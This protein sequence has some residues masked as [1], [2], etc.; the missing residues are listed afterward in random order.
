MLEN[1]DRIYAYGLKTNE[2]G[3]NNHL[4]LMG[5]TFPGGQGSALADLYNIKSL[6]SVGEGHS[7]KQLGKWLETQ[8]NKNVIAS[9]HSKGAT[10]SMIVGAKWPDKIK[11]ANCLNPTGLSGSTLRRYHDTWVN[12]S[13]KPAINVLINEGDIVPYLDMGYLPGTTIRRIKRDTPK[14]SINFN[15]PSFLSFL[16][17]GYEDHIHHKA[18][19]ENATVE[20][21]SVE[22]MNKASVRPVFNNMRA[23]VSWL[24]FPVAYLAVFTNIVGRKFSRFYQQHKHFILGLLLLAGIALLLAISFTPAAPAL[25]SAVSVYLMLMN[26]P[27]SALTIGTISVVLVST[28]AAFAPLITALAGSHLVSVANK[29]VL[30]VFKAFALVTGLTLGALAGF[31]E[32]GVRA[33]FKTSLKEGE[34]S[35]IDNNENT[36]SWLPGSLGSNSTGG[37]NNKSPRQE[38]NASKQSNPTLNTTE[39]TTEDKDKDVVHAL[40]SEFTI[41]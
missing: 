9:G 26:L 38:V 13:N 5:T 29:V 21:V 7:F 35:K 16:A 37:D 28:A 40:E 15:F 17:R 36:Y 8:Q 22:E 25:Y 39:N 12:T 34:Y 3:A 1:Q 27:V 18:G 41:I 33:L 23:M 19:R 31:I 30:G 20:N 6:N 32:L 24:T 10:M 2:P 14:L 4:L 11:E